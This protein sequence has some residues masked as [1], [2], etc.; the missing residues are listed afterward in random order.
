[1]DF[2]SGLIWWLFC[3]E[4]LW[5]WCSLVTRSSPFFLDATQGSVREMFKGLEGILVSDWHGVQLWIISR[6]CDKDQVMTFQLELSFGPVLDLS[7][8][9]GYWSVQT[10]D[11]KTCPY[12]ANREEEEEIAE[13]LEWRKLADS[14][15]GWV[16]MLLMSHRL[17]P[18]LSCSLPFP[19]VILIW[20]PLQK[21]PFSCR[22]P[23]CLCMVQ[24]GT[25]VGGK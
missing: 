20:A 22:R 23:L 4:S 11:V 2:Y 21:N 18:L 5:S 10:C 24:Q 6:L 17:H 9:K 7:S 25:G 15:L 3:H 13:R 1:M 14:G 8:R 19:A 12:Q 16:G